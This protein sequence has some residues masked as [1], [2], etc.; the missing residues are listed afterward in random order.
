MNNNVLLTVI[1][2][3]V[4][5]SIIFILL[6]QKVLA[7]DQNQNSSGAILSTNVVDMVQIIAGIATAAAVVYAGLTFRHSRQYTQITMSTNFLKD[8]LNFQREIV[9]LIAQAREK[10]I[11]P[12]N[13]DELKRSIYQYISTVEWFCFFVKTKDIEDKRIITLF[14]PI[15][16]SA[17]VWYN[18]YFPKLYRTDLEEN[19]FSNLKKLY[20]ELEK[21]KSM[22]RI[23][24]EPFEILNELKG[25]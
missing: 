18:I 25:G 8:L 19:M 11:D 12:A 6:D 21:D 9:K 2:S 14:W 23:H 13:D 4:I 20:S 22:Q 7:Q 10:R 5:I 3:L 24:F 1:F 17:N 15:I 16:K